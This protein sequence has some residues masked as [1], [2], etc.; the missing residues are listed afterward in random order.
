MLLKEEQNESTFLEQMKNSFN[1]LPLQSRERDEYTRLL[2]TCAQFDDDGKLVSLFRQI[3]STLVGGGDTNPFNGRAF[4]T[5]PKGII[6]LSLDKY[7]EEQPE[8][9]MQSHPI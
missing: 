6:Q 2:P 7:G 1:S 9:S 8:K 3:D 5:G 4:I